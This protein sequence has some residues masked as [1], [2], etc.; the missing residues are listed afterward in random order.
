MSR[1]KGIRSPLL[2][3]PQVGGLAAGGLQALGRRFG[4]AALPRAAVAAASRGA[5]QPWWGEA[6]RGGGLSRRRASPGLAS[7]CWTHFF[8]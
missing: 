6:A 7:V 1:A 4:A 2:G 8:V 3:R 5:S